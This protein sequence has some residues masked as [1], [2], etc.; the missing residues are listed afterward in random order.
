MRQ[1]IG[2]RLVPIGDV[3]DAEGHV[4]DSPPASQFMP[5]NV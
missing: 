1:M 4:G 5:S 2:F 3:G